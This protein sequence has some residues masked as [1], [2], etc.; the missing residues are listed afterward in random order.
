MTT[1]PHYSKTT[2]TSAGLL[3]EQ[4]TECLVALDSLQDHVEGVEFNSRDYS[5]AAF[6]AAAAERAAI[7]AKL[8]EVRAYFEAHLDAA[9]LA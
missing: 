7:F 3:A 4:Y 5:P 6:T 8:K 2:G 1:T 9:L